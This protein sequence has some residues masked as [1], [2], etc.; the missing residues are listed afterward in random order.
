MNFID[1][2]VPECILILFQL[3]WLDF[4]V[5]SHVNCGFDY[6]KVFNGPTTKSPLVGTYCNNNVPGDFTAES[7]YVTIL[8][9]SDY[10]VPEDGWSLKWE[11][12]ASG[13]LVFYQNPCVFYSGS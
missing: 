1:L 7:N 10:S 11:A 6:V 12:D 3:R 2:S 9:Q 4:K 13:K 5:E 8:F